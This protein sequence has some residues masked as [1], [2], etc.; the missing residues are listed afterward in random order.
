MG[1][2]PHS[3][4]LAFQPEARHCWPGTRAVLACRRIQLNHAYAPATSCNMSVLCVPH[5]KKSLPII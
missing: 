2:S 3:G 4:G 5:Q 1:K